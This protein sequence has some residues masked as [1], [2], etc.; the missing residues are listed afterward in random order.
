M[1]SIDGTGGL[2]WAVMLAAGPSK[3]VF[4]DTLTAY[5]EAGCSPVNC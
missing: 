1:L 5:V 2:V 3:T 4:A